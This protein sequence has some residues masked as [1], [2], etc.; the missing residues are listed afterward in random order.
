[1]LDNATTAL[2]LHAVAHREPDLGRNVLSAAKEVDDELRA[3][4]TAVLDAVADPSACA[5]ALGDVLS[6][7]GDSR[8]V[9]ECYRAAFYLDPSSTALRDNPLYAYFLAARSGP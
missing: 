7:T 2:L 4:L 3:D 6:R 5:R 8:A 9:N 1:M